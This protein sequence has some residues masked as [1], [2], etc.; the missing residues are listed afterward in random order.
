M[1]TG[2]FLLYVQG[3]TPLGF[4]LEFTQK[5]SGPLTLRA[6][7]ESGRSLQVD[8]LS[9]RRCDLFPCPQLLVEPHWDVNLH[10]SRR[11]PIIGNDLCC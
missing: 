2:V 8:S 3:V 4:G 11:L 9:F 1:K 7:P 5:Y 6:E 10:F